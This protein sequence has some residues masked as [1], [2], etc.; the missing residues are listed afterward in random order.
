MMLSIKS[1]V[2]SFIALRRLSSKSGNASRSGDA[3]FRFRR[4]SHCSAKFAT[5][6][7]DFG[8]ASIRQQRIVRNTAPEK[9]RKT[10]SEG[11]IVDAID[12]VCCKVWRILFNAEQELRAGQ[13]ELQRRFDA[14]LETGIV[15][16]AFTV[17]I[18]QRLKL[19]IVDR[20]PV[21]KS[22]Q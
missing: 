2:S 10:G 7:L 17:E 18:H 16:A 3:V 13:N 6:D 4:K 12:G 9:K 22:R 15:G 21:C 14:F 5:S 11:Q 8:S 1:V 19:G 20:P